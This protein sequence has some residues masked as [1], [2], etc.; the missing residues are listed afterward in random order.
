MIIK[1]NYIILYYKSKVR[2]LKNG[3]ANLYMNL[4]IQENGN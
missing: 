2:N 1:Q 4:V 3:H